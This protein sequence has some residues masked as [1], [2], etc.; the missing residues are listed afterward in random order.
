MVQISLQWEEPGIIICI[1]LLTMSIRENVI[2]V[3]LDVKL[4]NL[5]NIFGFC[6]NSSSLR[7]AHSRRADEA[8]QNRFLWGQWFW[9]TTRQV[10][11]SWNG[12]CRLFVC[13]LFCH[14]KL[15]ESF[16]LPNDSWWM[17]K[18]SWYESTCEWVLFSFPI[19]LYSVYQ[20]SSSSKIKK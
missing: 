10:W 8:Y 20:N 12:L 16:V 19:N 2:L 4:S 9:F 5:H 3:V 14:C 18:G 7:S 6:F 17:I 15:L 13:L 1:I 11:V